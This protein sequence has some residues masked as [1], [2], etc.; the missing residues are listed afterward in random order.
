VSSVS[1]N[2]V[3]KS[4]PRWSAGTRTLR[5]IVTRRLP[6]V[7]R[8]QERRWVLSDVSL[9][10]K[11]GESVGLIGPNGAG[12][13][14]LLRLVAGLGRPTRGTVERPGATAAVLNF[15]SWFD[16]ELTGRENAVT[17]LV[18]NGWRR[19]EANALLPAVLDFAELE[20]FAD[21]P[22]RTYSEGMKLRLAFGVVAQLRP[23]ALLIDEVI[24]VGDLRF[25][26]KCMERIQELRDG[27]TT[28]I[29]ASHDLDYI[30][31]NC[32]HA[33]W[34]QAG[35]VRT[36]GDSAAVADEYR[37]A[38]QS[39]TLDRTPA[40]SGEAS[41]ELELRR[42]RYGS[43]EATIDAVALRDRAGEAAAEIAT[44][45]EL[46]IALTVSSRNGPVSDPI[47]GV[48]IHRV[49]DGVI[50][51]ESS[52]ESDHVRVGTLDGELCVE[53][54]FDRLDLLPGEYR[55][56]AGLYRSDW[57]FAYDFH[58]QAYPLRVVGSQSDKGI[59]RPPHRWEVVR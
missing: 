14:T 8:G 9:H 58:W 43:Q 31:A 3:W 17:A 40:P 29:V 51:Y 52:T 16:G 4:Y 24:A 2:G 5:G 22:V 55:L 42:N 36:S 26:A 33:L 56:D 19:A 46:T 45:A 37:R 49:S 54:R 12:K 15:D 7:A 38:M 27:G 6:L 23:Q 20:D 41:G 34:L 57:E 25:Q 44:G 10:A 53:L 59:F 1:V 30:V 39:A 11:P 13:S 28:L 21:A 18:V 32:D 35:A 47:V 48:A 50:C